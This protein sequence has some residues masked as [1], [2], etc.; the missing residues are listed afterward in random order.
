MDEVLLTHYAPS[1]IAA[2]H[3]QGQTGYIEFHSHR[4]YEIYVFHSGECKYLIN[5]QIID[6]K[7]GSIICLDGSELHKAHVTGDISKYE[8]S[9]VHFSPDWL[10]PVLEVL[11]AAFLLEPFETSPHTVF[12]PKDNTAF[13]AL[14]QAGKE[15]AAL[16]FSPYSEETEA[17]LKN[18]LVQFLFLFYRLDKTAVLD[19]HIPKSEKSRYAEQIASYV[20][21]QFSTKITIEKI[22]QAL[23]LSQ[24]YISHL[25]KEITGYTVMEYVM[26]Y[27]FIQAK[28]L[29][30][31]S[32]QSTKLKDVASECGFESDSHFN[33]F[34]KKKTGMTPR[35]YQKLQKIDVK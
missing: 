31:L 5:N 10:R 33:R 12:L 27:R 20:Q 13:T 9:L 19:E 2:S 30:D 6:L 7:P 18:R 11:D 28:A 3:L 29:I 1:L 25:F 35:Q 21:Q 15:L 4:Q 24:S 34:F 22:A 8:R 14:D 32:G 17:E 23:N 16:S 26:D